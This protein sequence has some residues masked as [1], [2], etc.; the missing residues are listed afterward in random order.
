MT[1]GEHAI[2]TITRAVAACTPY[3]TALGPSLRNTIIASPAGMPEATSA[4]VAAQHD[5][6]DSGT[7]PLAVLKTRRLATAGATATTAVRER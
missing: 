7:A 2:T 6:A 5:T 3:A 4:R 1:R